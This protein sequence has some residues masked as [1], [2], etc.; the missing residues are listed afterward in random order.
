MYTC[1]Y[2]ETFNDVTKVVSRK[3][4]PLG[5]FSLPVRISFLSREQHRCAYSLSIL[6]PPA[7]D[8]A[9]FHFVINLLVYIFLCI[10]S[11]NQDDKK[12]QTL[13]YLNTHE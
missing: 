6:K 3:F 11:N 5:F 10:S 2:K 4:T 1:T 13:N 8:I 9:L 7:M 12:E